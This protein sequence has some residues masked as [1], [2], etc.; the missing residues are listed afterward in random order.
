MKEGLFCAKM[1]R[2]KSRPP[3]PAQ[4]GMGGYMR[5]KKGKHRRGKAERRRRVVR[6]QRMALAAAALVLVLVLAA[7]RSSSGEKE[8]AGS[9]KP[10]REQE[11]VPAAALYPQTS[12]KPEPE[13][14]EIQIRMVG[15]VILHE[16]VC[17]SCYENGTYDFSGLFTNIREELSKADLALVN[18]ETILGGEELG[19]FGY[20]QFNSPHQE[21]DALA[22]AGFNVI[23]QATNHALDAGVQGVD[24]T[25]QYWKNNYPGTAVLGIHQ[26]GTEERNIYVYEKER[27]RVSVLNYTYGTNVY[28]ELLEET[29]TRHLVDVLEEDMV[30]E[31]IRK[32][33]ELSDFVIVCPHWGTENSYEISQEQRHWTDIFSDCGVDLVLGTHPHVVQPAELVQRADGQE[34]LVYYSLGNFVSNQESAD[35]ALGAMAQITLWKDESGVS[36]REYGV[37]PVVTHESPEGEFTSYFLDQYTEEMARENQILNTGETFPL[38]ESRNRCREIFGSLVSESAG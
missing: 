14:V 36:I 15:D 11:A 34:M 16:D 2:E 17:E 32:A 4:I 29:G 9:G 13:G 1:I 3:T 31:D 35:N 30:R 22:G 23:L 18:Q 21:A 7:L 10:E 20:P 25:L 33:K 12:E 37:R 28:P 24:N 26:S 6:L 38:E 5:R 8:G 19:I 27:F